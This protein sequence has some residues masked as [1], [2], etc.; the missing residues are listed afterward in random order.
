MSA[1]TQRADILRSCRHVRFV[2]RQER[3]HAPQRTRRLF[4]QLVGRATQASST[5]NTYLGTACAFRTL[6]KNAMARGIASLVAAAF[7]GTS[8]R[9]LPG[10]SKSWVALG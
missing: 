10:S 5:A 3:T 4:G 2:P 7:A 6:A 1:V 9:S 8:R